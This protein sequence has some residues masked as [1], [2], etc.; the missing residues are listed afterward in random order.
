MTTEILKKNIIE[1]LQ[2]LEEDCLYTSKNHF[3][4]AM[5]DS[6]LHYMFGILL[7]VCAAISTQYSIIYIAIFSTIIASLQTFISPDKKAEK[8]Q[9]HG[10]R[11]LS[12]KKLIR[13]YRTIN[14]NYEKEENILQQINTFTDKIAEYN[15]SAPEIN[16]IAYIMTKAGIKSG[17]HIYDVD[18]QER[19]K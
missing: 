18:N 16:P 10:N 11:F 15:N 5:F 13:Q 19:N 17:E 3:N 14:I 2:R 6:S 4:N 12:L 7:I 8:H 1:E 9:L